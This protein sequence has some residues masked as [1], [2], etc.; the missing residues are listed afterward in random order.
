MML[1]RILFAFGSLQA[2][3]QA[4][5]SAASAACGTFCSCTQLL[6]EA[7]SA[8]ARAATSEAS[9]QAVTSSVQEADAWGQDTGDFALALLLSLNAA[10]VIVHNIFSSIEH[11]LTGCPLQL[12]M[13]LSYR[14][15]AF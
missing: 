13:P 2:I 4:T 3:A 12:V 14:H 6:W 7:V 9:L 1:C 15:A 11:A 10:C 8:V 5:S